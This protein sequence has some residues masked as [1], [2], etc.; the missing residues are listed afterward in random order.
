MAHFKTGWSQK[1]QVIDVIV[2]G[3]ENLHVGDMVALNEETAT[4][5]KVTALKDAEYIIA[6]SD[7]TMEYG[8]APIERGDYRYSDIVAPSNSKKKVAVF[9]ILDKSDILLD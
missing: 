7:M 9:F 6:Q 8:H 1:E 3:S 2:S 5:T 4:I